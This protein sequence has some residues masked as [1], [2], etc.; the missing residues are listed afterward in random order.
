MR[1][2]ASLVIAAALLAATAASAVAQESVFGIRG[3]GFLGWPVSA[4]SAGMGGGDALFDGSSAVN[5][6]SLASWHSLAG[7]AVGAQSQRSVDAGAGTASLRSMRF[8][9]FGFATPIGRRLVVGVSA[10]DFLN[11]N[12]DV[13]QSDTVVPR[14]S[15][16]PVTDRTK[17]IGGVSDIRFAA[18][19]WLTDRIA[20]GAGF[21]VL[22]GSTQTAIQRQFPSDSAYST[23]AQITQ[24][25]Y[26][27][28]AASLG[29][30][31]TPA[32][33]IVLGA[34][35]QFNGPLRANN[36]G[37]SARV[38]LPT[39]LSAG[40]YVGTLQGITVSSFV[41]HANWSVASADLV[42]AG[43]SG[44]RDVWSLGVGA[45]VMALKMFGQVTP[46]RAGYRWRQ[47]PFLVPEPNPTLPTQTVTVPL[48]EH[49]VSFGLG[50]LM[51]G[52]RANLDLA[53]ES[54]SRAAGAVSER[55]TTL[56]VGVAIFP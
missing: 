17:S 24:T 52:G 4:R 42:A 25:E 41:S 7:W 31:F 37:A 47:L 49:A 10:S 55:F 21:H 40:I 5:P 6:A 20:F 48:S 19:Y 30:F 13:Q 28:S 36:P 8:P 15:A 11:R 27:G 51:A 34:S 33:R 39:E 12:W 26:R 38:H 56:L 23:F 46:L 2:R 53:L 18:A 32:P 45:Q 44:A 9:L 16:V 3:L 50:F 1:R 29:V 35:A 43:Q 54:G 22:T 14:D